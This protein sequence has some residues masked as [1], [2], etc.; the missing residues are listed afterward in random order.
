MPFKKKLNYANVL[1]IVFC[2]VLLSCG[3]NQE[4]ASASFI[5][6][7]SYATDWGYS[8]D[9]TKKEKAYEILQKTLRENNSL[10][11]KSKYN[12]YNGLYFYHFFKGD[13]EKALLYSDS[14][15]YAIAATKNK[16]K[17][18]KELATAHYCKGDALFRLHAYELAYKNYFLAKRLQPIVVDQC[19]NSNYSYRIAMILFRQSKYNEAINYFH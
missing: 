9:E 1:L 17:Y 18:I 16:K 10:N 7:I 11:H 6:S 13:F 3:K 2:A 5:D 12:I 15:L 14:M 19:A 4:T 8:D